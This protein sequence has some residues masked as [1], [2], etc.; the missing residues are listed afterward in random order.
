MRTFGSQRMFLHRPV[1]N[2]ILE[3]CALDVVYLFNMYAEWGGLAH[4]FTRTAKRVSDFVDA[5]SVRPSNLMSLV[6]FDR[7]PPPAADD[8]SATPPAP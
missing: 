3:Y 2:Y 7:G 5:A 8:Y 4:V 1:P 6:D